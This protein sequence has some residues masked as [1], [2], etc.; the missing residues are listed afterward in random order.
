M[1]VASYSDHTCFLCGTFGPNAVPGDDVHHTD[2]TKESRRMGNQYFSDRT[3]VD[4]RGQRSP[5]PLSMGC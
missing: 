4:A 5:E 3:N 2:G 1:G